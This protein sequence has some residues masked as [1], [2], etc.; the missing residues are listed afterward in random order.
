M[1]AKANLVQE[2]LIPAVDE[3]VLVLAKAK[4]QAKAMNLPKVPPPQSASSSST[5]N[6][7]P[8]FG[9]KAKAA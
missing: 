6:I 4:A 7:H 9:G 2:E 1:G 8:L 5:D 3:E